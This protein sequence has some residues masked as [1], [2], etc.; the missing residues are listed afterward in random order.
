MANQVEIRLVLTQKPAIVFEAL[1]DDDMVKE[2]FA[3]ATEIDL[4]QNRYDFWGRC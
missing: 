3:E 1:T 4:S 2:W